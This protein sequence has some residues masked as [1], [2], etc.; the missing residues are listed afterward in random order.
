MRVY[1]P[2]PVIIP[3]LKLATDFI[4][5]TPRE[6]LG[7]L[8]APLDIVIAYQADN[9]YIFRNKNVP[10]LY[11]NDVES[12]IDHLLS[13]H[14]R[15]MVTLYGT[16]TVIGDDDLIQRAIAEVM[17]WWGRYG[18]EQMVGESVRRADIYI[19]HISQWVK[20]YNRIIDEP[21]MLPYYVAGIFDEDLIDR[22]IA[23]G[24]D[25]EIVRAVA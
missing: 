14:A 3:E 12:S 11:T 8:T 18:N 4:A 24:V 15:A 22:A 2:R 13:E 19:P 21:A 10:K 16:G 7:S 5:S 9:S 6:V 23:D 17:T 25:A 1:T 20:R